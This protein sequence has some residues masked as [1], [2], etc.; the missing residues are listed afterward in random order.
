MQ[1]VQ[2]LLGQLPTPETVV[3]HPVRQLY[4]LGAKCGKPLTWAILPAS[5]DLEQLCACQQDR[6]HGAMPAPCTC[7]AI[8]A[9]IG[10]EV[11]G[12]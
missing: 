12:R 10:G 4:E 7:V 8:T 11:I 1:V 3:L 9:L 2:H 6:A 5:P